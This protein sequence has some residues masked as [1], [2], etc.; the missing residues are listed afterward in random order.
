M[1]SNNLYIT[2]L[3]K[4]H[5]LKN[6]D[7]G[8]SDLNNHLNKYALKNQQ[9]DSSTTYVACLGSDVIGYYTITVASVIHENAAPRISKGLPKYPIP[10]ALLARL[11]VSKEFQNK[12]I[13]RGLLKNCLI[14]INQAADLIGIR[15]LLVHAKDEKARGWYQQFDFEP[16]PTDPLHL[17]LMLKDIRAMLES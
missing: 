17:F 5:D 13:G 10:V 15:A 3:S 11:A 6:F 9:S 8:N 7:C 2:K 14:R 1:A 4:S 16:S 12:G